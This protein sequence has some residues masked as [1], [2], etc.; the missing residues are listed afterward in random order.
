MNPN[1]LEF[2]PEVT[3]DNNLCLTPVILGCTD[4]SFVEYNIEANVDDG[5]C[6]AS[7][8]MGCTNPNYLE[9]WAYDTLSFSVSNLDSIPN[10]DD[11]SCTYIILEGCT[12]E[13]FV[14]YNA[15]SNVDDNSC[16]DLIF[17]GCTDALAFNFDPL[18][19]TDNGLCEPVVIGCMD[20]NYLEFNPNYNTEDNSM[21]LTEVVF[22]CNDEAAINYNLESNTNDGSCFYNLAQITFEG[23]ADGIIAFNSNVN[24]LGVGSDYSVLW[25]FGDGFSSNA[26]NPTY[27]YTENGFF[28]VVLTVSN[29]L[30]QVTESIEIEIINAVVDIDE[31]ENNRMV[32]SIQYFDIM[33]REVQGNNLNQHQIYIQK[34]RYDDGSYAFI[35]NVK[36]N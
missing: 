11:G 36:L 8:V 29:G 15:L 22:G 2:N 16:E 14:Q 23:F 7:V 21:C 35:K 3:I 30:I 20:E 10:T 32:I 33:G 34:I 9:Y 24:E 19:N 31:L 1:F 28:E 25:N 6:G 5:S 27:T 12:D 13:N 26:F 17:I 18:A 4:V